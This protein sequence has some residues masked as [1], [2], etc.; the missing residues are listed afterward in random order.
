MN[1]TEN[2]IPFAWNTN[3][4]KYYYRDEWELYDLK[5]DPEEQN[6]IFGKDSSVSIVKTLQEELFNWL[7]QTHDPWLCAPNAVLQDKGF[8]KTN[9]QC[10]PLY[11]KL[12]E[13][14]Q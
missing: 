9:P 11:N 7:N 2:H 4:K 10:L 1:K 6:N 13:Y 12:D 5:L 14:L 8:Y 3:L